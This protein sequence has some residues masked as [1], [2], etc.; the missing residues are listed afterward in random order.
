MVRRWLAD[1]GGSLA[2]SPFARAVGGFMIFTAMGQSVYLVVGPLVGRL[3]TPAAVGAY[4]LLLTIVMMAT[5]FVCLFYDNAIPAAVDDDDARQLTAGSLGICL[6]LCPVVGIAIS[7]L[8]GLDGLSVELPAWSGLFATALLFAFVAGQL[9]QAWHIRRSQTMTIAHGNLGLNLVRGATQV[10]GGVFLPAWWVLMAGEIAGRLAYVAYLGRHAEARVFLRPRLGRDVRQ[11]LS[12]YREFPLVLLPSQAVEALAYF[13]QI[14]GLGM[15]FGPAALGQYYLM[16]RTLDLPVAFFFRSLSDVFYARQ[17]AD[18]R[19]APERIRPF[20][21]KSALLLAGIGFVGG[22]PLMLF[23][24]EIFLVVFGEGWGPAGV[25]AAVMTPA[26]V[27]NLA[28]APVSRVFNLT[29]RPQLRFAFGFVNLVGTAVVIG[30]AAQRSFSLLE[31]VIGI[32]LVTSLS[33]LTYFGAGWIAAAHIRS[34]IEP[35]PSAT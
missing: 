12:R 11:V 4:G 14:A 3:F 29:T 16:R 15:L 5:A 25:L 8:A 20:F 34:V 13:L 31:T 28:V 27:L 9:L 33:Y 26:A 32:S 1:Q 6:V 18:A 10:G 21:T 2:R 35:S 19:N 22:L 30:L 7:L 23:G 17:A 24:R